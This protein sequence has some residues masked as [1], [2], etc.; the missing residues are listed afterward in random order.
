MTKK[1][2]QDEI[3]RVAVK[4]RGQHNKTKQI[5]DEIGD[6]VSNYSYE[7]VEIFSN[8]YINEDT[9]L[10][11]YNTVSEMI[12]DIAFKIMKK[13]IWEQSKKD[14]ITDQEFVN[15]IARQVEEGMSAIEQTLDL[16]GEFEEFNPIIARL[17]N[18]QKLLSKSNL[19][20]EEDIYLKEALLEKEIEEL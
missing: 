18:I 15:E 4:I 6:F 13:K 5:H 11:Y 1:E 19:L 9:R 10:C 3:R 17:E 8:S 12:H 2:I 16:E 20:T 14:I 7:I